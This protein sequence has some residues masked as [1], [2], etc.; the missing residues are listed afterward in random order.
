MRSIAYPHRAG[1]IFTL[2]VL[3]A[4]LLL[5]AACTS[6]HSDPALL[7]V[8]TPTDFSLVFR[9]IGDGTSSQ[10][11]SQTTVQTI[12]PNRRMGLLR[13]QAA[14]NNRY[15][16]FLRHLTRAEYEALF[17]L[18]SN[19]HLLAEPSSPGSEAFALGK[20]KAAALYEVEISAFGRTNIYR[21]TPSESPPTVQLL[22][23]LIELRQAS[24]R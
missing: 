23:R 17:K 3:A 2:L 18:V 16:P 8:R 12:E 24:P 7:S 13:G 10:P 15:P 22:T 9:V 4:T 6:P 14:L 1:L 19:N 21:T 11:M 5:P 20:T